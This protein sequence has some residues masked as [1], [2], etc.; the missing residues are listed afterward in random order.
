MQRSNTKATLANLAVNMGLRINTEAPQG[1]E[2]LLTQVTRD[3]PSK[4]NQTR[5][6]SQKSR[7]YIVLSGVILCYPGLYC[8][9]WGYLAIRGTQNPPLIASVS[10]QVQ[11]EG[12]QMLNEK[13]RPMAF[14]LRYFH[15]SLDCSFLLGDT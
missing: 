5:R 8:V 9:I 15:L 3:N 2:T 12:P 14:L 13:Q 11:P 10:V 7:G 4:P 6:N 1:A